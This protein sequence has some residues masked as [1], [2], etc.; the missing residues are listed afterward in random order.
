MNVTK[1]KTFVDLVMASGLIVYN[2]I[3]I[4]TFQRKNVK[5]F[6]DITF[7]TPVLAV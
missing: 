1:K 5:S 4:P 6:I 7:A 2:K 3:N